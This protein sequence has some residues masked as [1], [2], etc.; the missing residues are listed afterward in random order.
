MQYAIEAF[1]KDFYVL[2]SSQKIF[3]DYTLYKDFSYDVKQNC[4]TQFRKKQ[5]IFFMTG[6]EEAELSCE[7]TRF[8][9]EKILEIRY[10][11]I[12]FETEGT[13]RMGHISEALESLKSICKKVRVK[14]YR[15]VENSIR[16]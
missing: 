7:E 11:C 5:H 14:L 16:I 8:L 10:V 6:L 2:E 13:D 4:I 9:R 15:Y 1:G 12:I 3:T